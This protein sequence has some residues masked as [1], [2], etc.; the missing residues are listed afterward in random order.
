MYA[1]GRKHAACRQIVQETSKLLE[2]N[3]K[4]INGDYGIGFGNKLTIHIIGCHAIRSCL[5][6][7]NIAGFKR[8]IVI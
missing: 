1:K 3:R 6:T 7:E 5:N 2:V 4:V 8:Q